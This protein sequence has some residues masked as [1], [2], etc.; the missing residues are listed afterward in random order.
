MNS[1]ETYHFPSIIFCLT[2]LLIFIQ[3]STT[4]P[5]SANVQNYDDIGGHAMW[6]RPSFESEMIDNVDESDSRPNFFVVHSAYNR[7]SQPTSS[8]PVRRSNFWKRANFWRKRANF[9]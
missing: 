8:E 3:C 4:Q 6:F 1:K 2:I 7:L 9:W 5:L